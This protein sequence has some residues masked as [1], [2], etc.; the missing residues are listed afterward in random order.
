MKFHFDKPGCEELEPVEV[1]VTTEVRGMARN[2]RRPTSVELSRDD[3]VT[4]ASQC[5][6]QQCAQFLFNLAMT[7]QDKD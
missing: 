1:H 5:T 2:F 6:P 4:I 3:I 7:L